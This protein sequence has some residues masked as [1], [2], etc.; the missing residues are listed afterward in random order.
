MRF[1]KNKIA[2]ATGRV[3]GLQPIDFKVESLSQPDA[4]QSVKI[5][6]GFVVKYEE[7]NSI[8]TEAQTPSR[9][10]RSPAETPARRKRE[11]N[12]NKNIVKNYARAMVNFALSGIATAMVENLL[13]K[14]K[15][16]NV[17]LRGFKKF[18]EEQKEEVTSIRRLRELLLPCDKD[19]STL[20]AYKRVF[21]AIGMLFIRDFSVNWIYSSKVGDKLT[22][23]KYR[24][25]MMRRVQNPE[26]FTYI[27]GFTKK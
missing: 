6:Q 1:L 21:K 20:A 14:E 16:L 26:F 22:H 8:P 15:P 5:E 18:M 24:F 13:A 3:P 2:R 10:A 23:V 9:S 7:T 4:L 27:E 19:S 17:N 12:V 11:S 25:K